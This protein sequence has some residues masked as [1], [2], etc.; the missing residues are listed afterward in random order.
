[1]NLG[2]TLKNWSVGIGYHYSQQKCRE[3]ETPPGIVEFKYT[4][5]A[6]LD[7]SGSYYYCSCIFTS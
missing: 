1:M 7:G 6:M 5:M 2:I 3:S 4:A